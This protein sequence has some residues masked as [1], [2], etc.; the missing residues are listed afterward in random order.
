MSSTIFVNV[1][2]ALVRR[3]IRL[4]SSE[5]DTSTLFRTWSNCVIFSAS[6]SRIVE[7]QWMRT[8]NN[9]SNN[10]N[11]VLL[12]NPKTYFVV[13]FLN[14]VQP[15]IVSYGVDSSEQTNKCDSKLFTSYSIIINL[16]YSIEEIKDSIERGK[17]DKRHG[18]QSN[19]LT[20]LTFSYLWHLN[21]CNAC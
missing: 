18:R 10:S 15:F 7:A 14:W 19:Y 16:T 11:S 2:G 17:K 9:S 1:F 20:V 6:S 8:S 13:I 5:V 21:K 12:S 3:A 4:F